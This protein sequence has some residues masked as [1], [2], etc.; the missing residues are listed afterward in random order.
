LSRTELKARGIGQ[1]DIDQAI[2]EAIAA[3]VRKQ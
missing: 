2:G 3:F 1:D